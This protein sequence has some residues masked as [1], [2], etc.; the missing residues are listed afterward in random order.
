MS[1]TTGAEGPSLRAPSISRSWLLLEPFAF[2]LLHLLALPRFGFLLGLKPHNDFRDGH[3]DPP[4]TSLLEKA[5]GWMS[6][7]SLQA[8]P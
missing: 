6:I 5:Y 3:A 8:S 1:G 4:H 2:S 7:R